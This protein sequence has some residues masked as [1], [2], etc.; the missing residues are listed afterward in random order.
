MVDE[1][2]GWVPLPLAPQGME[3]YMA[4]WRVYEQHETEVMMDNWDVVEEA[5]QIR[6]KLSVPGV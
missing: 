2:D 6:R 4:G 5:T 1:D 3:L